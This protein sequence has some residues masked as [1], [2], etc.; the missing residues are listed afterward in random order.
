[1]GTCWEYCLGTQVYVL[2]WV[3]ILV[4]KLYFKIPLAYSFLKEEC[5]LITVHRRPLLC[6]LYIFRT[7]CLMACCRIG[8]SLRVLIAIGGGLFLMVAVG[9]LTSPFGSTLYCP[10]ALIRHHLSFII[11]SELAIPPAMIEFR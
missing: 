6:L 8:P 3:F 7:N 5:L 11:L 10:E 9:N 2:A 4:E 1:M